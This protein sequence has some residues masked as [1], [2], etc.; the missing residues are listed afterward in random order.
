[1]AKKNGNW[2][3]IILV[4][5][6]LFIFSLKTETQATTYTFSG[7]NSFNE[8][9]LYESSIKDVLEQSYSVTGNSLYDD[10]N[11][12]EDQIILIANGLTGYA[13]GCFGVCPRTGS[14]EFAGG[15]EKVSSLPLDIIGRPVN[16]CDEFA[17]AV[18]SNPIL[19]FNEG[20]FHFV[21]KIYPEIY[22]GERFYSIDVL[23]GPQQIKDRFP[24]PFA[25]LLCH[26]D[27][28][29]GSASVVSKSLFLEE[30]PDPT[31]FKPNRFVK[32]FIDQFTSSTTSTS[33]SGGGGCDLF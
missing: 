22:M 25:Y 5:G 14:F 9:L 8:I 17:D 24:N 19:E 27:Y 21:F 28:F 30:Q 6:L 23:E 4:I 20:T 18:A 29:V 12:S 1:M 3:W 2:M 13:F 31:I 32:N 33:S 11:V 16:N 7:P 10:L 15:F 26:N